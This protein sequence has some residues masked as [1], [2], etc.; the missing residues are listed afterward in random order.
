MMPVEMRAMDKFKTYTEG[1]HMGSEGKGIT[2]SEPQVSD[3]S[4]WV[5]S[6]TSYKRT[7]KAIRKANSL[8]R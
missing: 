7:E 4:K 6:C 5:Y 8:G 3:F 2:G 1:L